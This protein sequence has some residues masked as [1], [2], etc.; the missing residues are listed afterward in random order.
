MSNNLLD[1]INEN[2]TGDVVSKLAEFLGESSNNTSSAL[3][4][5]IPS[6]LAGLVNKSADMQGASTILSLLNQKSDVSGILNNLVTAFS[7]GEGTNQLLAVGAKLLNSIFG[8]KTD[9]VANLIANS[10]GISKTSSN[11]LLGLLMPLIFGVLGKTVKAEGITSPAGLVSFLSKQSGFLKNLLPA[12]LGS[13]LGIANLNDLG[14]KASKTAAY[15]TEERSGGLLRFLPWLLLPLLFVLG[16]WFLNN[17]EKPT[18]PVPEVSVPKVSAPDVPMPPIIP[19]VVEKVSGFFETTLPSGYAIKGAKEGIEYKLIGFI[20]DTGKAVDETTWFT[21]D[22]I[23]FDTDKAAIKPESNV[24]LANIA[25]ILRAFPAVKIK[26]GGYTDNTGDA[27]ANQVLSA[28]RATAVK[29]TLIGM[30]IDAGRIEAEG[31]GSAY[32]VASNDTPEGRQQNRRID[33][34]VLA[35]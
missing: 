18:A 4:S 5:A 2:I 28:D 35:K 34:R 17:L 29:K 15:V 1:L 30:G 26:I 32:P 16:W 8:Y 19:H 9:D 31:Y 24:Q 13:I 7:G 12:G 33:I 10:S 20:Q 22:G 11:S 27:A 14:K 6:I 21:M 25:E 3:S 23:T